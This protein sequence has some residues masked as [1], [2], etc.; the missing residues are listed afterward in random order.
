MA[1]SFP[2]HNALLPCGKLALSIGRV[3]DNDIDNDNYSHLESQ[4]IARTAKDLA[5]TA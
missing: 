1:L 2:H 3:L 4:S 5:A